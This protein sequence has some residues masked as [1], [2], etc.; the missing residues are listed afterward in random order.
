MIS[1]TNIFKICLIIPVV[2]LLRLSYITMPEKT[3]QPFFDSFINGMFG[4]SKTI[5]DTRF[6]QMLTGLAFIL[7]FFILFG[8]YIYNDLRISSIYAFTRVNNKSYWILK[9]ILSLFVFALSYSIICVTINV[10]ITY[11]KCE[12]A[13][14][15]S[16]EIV[17]L[18][19]VI[20][21]TTMLLWTLSILSNLLASFI[22]G[23]ISTFVVIGIY[24]ISTYI[25]ANCINMNI[26]SSFFVRR[27]N[28][29]ANL[30]F[31]WE[32]CRFRE[33]VIYWI[34]CAA[35]IIILYYLY[36]KY[37]DIG[38]NDKEKQ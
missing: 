11:C 24:T 14:I 3:E 35:I 32:L 37:A 6:N 5:E 2:F 21:L 31:F 10:L 33:S 16:G 19:K 1:K 38:L 36:V 27:I 13:N 7:L 29:T 23:Y 26:G 18:I 25:S 17:S 34:I 20:L 9:K 8:T 15:G 22:G 30:M 12:N 4:C 28:P